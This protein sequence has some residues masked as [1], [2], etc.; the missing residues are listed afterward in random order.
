MPVRESNRESVAIFRSPVRGTQASS[1]SFARNS[2]N[3]AL[4]FARNPNNNALMRVLFSAGKTFFGT[5]CYAAIGCV[6]VNDAAC[7]TI[8]RTLLSAVIETNEV[9]S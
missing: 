4:S 7:Q 2:R 6:G 9:I 5:N 1:L 3:N 8:A